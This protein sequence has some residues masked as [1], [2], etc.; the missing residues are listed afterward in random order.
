MNCFLKSSAVISALFLVFPITRAEEPKWYDT[1]DHFVVR[2]LNSDD[3]GDYITVA[4]EGTENHL[5]MAYNLDIMLPAG[6]TFP[7]TGSQEDGEYSYETGD[8]FHNNE[9]GIYPT[10]RHPQFGQIPN[11]TLSNSIKDNGTRAKVIC[12]SLKNEEFKKTT[13]AVFNCY[14][15]V[16]PLAKAGVND[17]KMKDMV[18]NTKNPDTGYP[19][20]WA[21]GNTLKNVAWS[22]M[23]IPAERTVEVSI[24]TTDKWA[25]LIL[26]FALN[27]LPEG[28]TAYTA[29]RVNESAQVELEEVTGLEPYKPYFVYAPQGWTATLTGTA[30]ADDFPAAP[31]LLAADDY[32]TPHPADAIASNG[33]LCANIRPHSRTEGYVLTTVG[34]TPT[35]TRVTSDSP[36]FLLTGEVYIPTREEFAEAPESLSLKVVEKDP[37]LTGIAETVAD[38]ND[39][40]EPLYNLQGI[41]VTNPRPGNLYISCGRLIRK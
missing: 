20:Q 2:G 19:I 16:H 18:F 15:K 34:A 36:K 26:P 30:S 28:V 7:I 22:T 24:S 37:P 5:Y 13:G 21:P 27:E 32:S 33:V 3:Y 35:L 10:T 29:A 25:P 8:V 38:D 17:V 6:V 39:A 4:I 11:H 9:D 12:L 1:T 41:R 31:A 40:S 23:T 14:V